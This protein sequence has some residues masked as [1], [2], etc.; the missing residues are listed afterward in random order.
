MIFQDPYS[1]LNPRQTVGP[2]HRR[3]VRD[4][5]APRGTCAGACRRCMDR[6][7]LNPEH[8]NRYPHEF[9]GGQRQRIG[10]ARALALQPAA[11]HLRRAGLGA[12][13]VDPG[14]DP[15]PARGP[16]GR[17][18][19]DLPLHLARPR[20]SCGTSRT[21]SRSCTW[22]GSSRSA[23]ADELYE[24]PQHPY[25]A[26]LLSAVPKGHTNGG[27]RASRIVLTGD[28]PSPID[29]PPGCLPHALSEGAHRHRQGRRGAGELPDG[30]S[31]AR[32]RRAAQPGRLLVPA[33]AGRKAASGRPMREREIANRSPSSRRS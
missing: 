7:G 21:G 11:D 2:D 16:P 9:S 14:A 32:R 22:A 13:R 12:R 30:V 31:A 24:N 10:V 3:P 25:T 26:A 33:E 5:A 1:S 18:Q 17:L 15:Q 27:S 20:R 8:Y 28:V 4:P 23:Q 19:P 6:V 29:P